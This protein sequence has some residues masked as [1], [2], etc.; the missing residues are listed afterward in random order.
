MEGYGWKEGRGW[1]K[2]VS[3]EW[4]KA[5]ANSEVGIALRINE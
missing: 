3:D 4:R 5:E 1:M 2:Q